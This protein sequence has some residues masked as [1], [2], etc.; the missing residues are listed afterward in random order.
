MNGAKETGNNYKKLIS[1]LYPARYRWGTYRGCCS[2]NCR[3]RWT[4]GQAAHTRNY[5]H[6]KC[7]E[8]IVHKQ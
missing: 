3:L 1:V 5:P 8:F 2:R 6:V 4:V 7:T